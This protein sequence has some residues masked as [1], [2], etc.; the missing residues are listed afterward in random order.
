M[1]EQTFARNLPQ[2]GAKTFIVTK[3]LP[4][5][6]ELNTQLDIQAPIPSAGIDLYMMSREIEIAS[7]LAS[8]KLEYRAR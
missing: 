1:Q 3:V 7:G 5:M 2:K 6:P 8:P 4:K